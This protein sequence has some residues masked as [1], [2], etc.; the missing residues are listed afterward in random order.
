M[1]MEEGPKSREDVLEEAGVLG[2][3]KKMTLL[4][5]YTDILRRH[6]NEKHWPGT[7]ETMGAAQGQ[8][9]AHILS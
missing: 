5:Y 7:G 4:R 8:P 9:S 1:M 2:V 3:G 6:T